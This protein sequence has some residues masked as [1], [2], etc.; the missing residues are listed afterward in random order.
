MP[1]YLVIAN[2][3]RHDPLVVCLTPSATRSIAAGRSRR[4][5]KPGSGSRTARATGETRTRTGTIQLRPS[6]HRQGHEEASG[7]AAADVDGHGAEGEGGPESLGHPSSHDVPG[8]C[9]QKTPQTDGQELVHSASCEP[10]AS[11]RCRRRPAFPNMRAGPR[12]LGLDPAYICLC[13]F[14]WCRP[15]SQVTTWRTPASAGRTGSCPASR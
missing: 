13:E 4:L 3:L 15:G 12:T 10:G 9:P 8:V 11:G 7:E 6:I 5:A 1:L 2:Y 14:R